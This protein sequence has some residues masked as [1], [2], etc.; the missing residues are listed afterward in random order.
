VD[1]NIHTLSKDGRLP[2]F[3][4]YSTQVRKVFESVVVVWCVVYSTQV[5]KVFELVVVVWC[6]VYSTQVRKAFERVLYLRYTSL[7]MLYVIC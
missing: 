1:G 3:E 6:V 7:I 5:R 2:F 4:Q